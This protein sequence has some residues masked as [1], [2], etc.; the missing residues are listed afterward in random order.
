MEEEV[1]AHLLPLPLYH[2]TSPL[3]LSF[4]VYFEMNWPKVFKALTF[5]TFPFAF[6]PPLPPSISP[7]L[8][9]LSLFVCLSVFCSHSPFFSLS[10]S[11]SLFYFP[12]A[13]RA[14]DVASVLL[15]LLVLGSW[16][17]VLAIGIGSWDS[18]LHMSEIS[19]DCLAE[20]SPL[21]KGSPSVTLSKV[22]IA[23]QGNPR[24]SRTCARNYPRTL[25]R[26]PRTSEAT[27]CGSP[28]PRPRADDG[29]LQESSF[30]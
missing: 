15:V 27:T 17:H 2:S 22:E 10:L 16:L 25:S 5:S 11:L 12:C 26:S 30:L 29:V 8:F 1:L 24:R 20:Q 13:T 3:Y 9:F 19:L 7:N 23:L 28:S 18:F 6:F 14:A 21:W 4:C